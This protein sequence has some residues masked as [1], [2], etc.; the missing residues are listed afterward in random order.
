MNNA[1]FAIVLGKY[2][3]VV[4]FATRIQPA[5][6]RLTA[7]QGAGSIRGISQITAKECAKGISAFVMSMRLFLLAKWGR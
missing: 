4:C 5:N 1:I 7:T 3:S 6:A 2:K